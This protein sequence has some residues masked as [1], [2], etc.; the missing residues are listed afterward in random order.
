MCSNCKPSASAAIQCA[1]VMKGFIDFSQRKCE[2]SLIT[3]VHHHGKMQFCTFMQIASQWPNWVK[4]LNCYR[5]VDLIYCVPTVPDLINFTVKLTWKIP[6]HI[7]S[8]SHSLVH[9]LSL[10][11]K[12]TTY[13][14]DHLILSKHLISCYSWPIPWFCRS[15]RQK[16]YNGQHTILNHKSFLL[17]YISK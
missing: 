15:Q 14:H 16:S 12:K 11:Q 9:S 3:Y 6:D 2:K 5:Y 8:P 7:K 17:C 10:S 13:F 4:L 1:S